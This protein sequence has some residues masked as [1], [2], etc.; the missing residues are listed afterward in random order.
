[1]EK[2]SIYVYQWIIKENEIRCY[3][4]NEKNIPCCVKLCGY[5]PP[6]ILEGHLENIKLEKK[7]TRR[8]L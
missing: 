7:R 5:K 1:M 4:L 3:A 8:S 2:I 6:L